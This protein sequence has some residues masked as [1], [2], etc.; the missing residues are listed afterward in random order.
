MGSDKGST[1][2]CSALEPES[3][4]AMARLRSVSVDGTKDDI[5]ARF[6]A[7]NKET[8]T[9]PWRKDAGAAEPE[10]GEASASGEEESTDD[11]GSE[12]VLPGNETSP[13]SDEVKDTVKSKEIEEIKVVDEAAVTDA[14]DDIKESEKPAE[15]EEIKRVGEVTA[16][17]DNKIADDDKKTTD[18]EEATEPAKIPEVAVSS[19][20]E[21]EAKIGTVKPASM[22]NL[23]QDWD[24]QWGGP[25]SVDT[26]RMT[27]TWDPSK[28][29]ASMAMKI[30]EKPKASPAV[31]FKKPVE[32]PKAPPAATVKKKNE[33][34]QAP[35]AAIAEPVSASSS[36][37]AG[38]DV[39]TDSASRSVTP[40]TDVEVTVSE[41]KKDAPTSEKSAPVQE[42]D[43]LASTT[44]TQAGE[45]SKK[46]RTRGKKGGKK[47]K[48]A[49]AQ[50]TKGSQSAASTDDAD[51]TEEDV[52]EAF[53]EFIDVSAPADANTGAIVELSSSVASTE[54]EDTVADKDDLDLSERVK[55]EGTEDLPAP[56]SSTS[57]PEAQ[58]T[59]E[60]IKFS[61]P[62]KKMAIH[63]IFLANCGKKE[64]VEASEPVDFF[65]APAS[66][67]PSSSAEDATSSMSGE[68]SEEK[69]KKFNRKSVKAQKLNTAN[70][71]VALPSEEGDGPVEATMPGDEGEHA[72]LESEA[73]AVVSAVKKTKKRG[74][75]GG[76]KVKKVVEEVSSDEASAWKPVHFAAFGVFGVAAGLVGYWMG[77]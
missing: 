59:E 45:P 32:K 11:I 48:K 16:I 74:K 67:A 27:A 31:N 69:A 19:E 63:P 52:T 22:A 6:E 24:A 9:V 3:A 66:P 39:T 38:S 15:A 1:N 18:V 17:D 49:A 75:K 29:F 51:T 28:F 42:K 54:P 47:A 13:Q 8:G 61:E 26:V 33:K 50:P 73:N 34:W 70:A 72:A 36:T 7:Q 44:G 55:S 77:A 76:R 71:F 30:S 62:V 57:T 10:V 25:K 35:P 65:P 53:P 68:P 2:Y 46:K 43:V 58:K 20:I 64:P 41:D 56:S 14:P 4:K 60:V 23:E 40:A 21:P 5:V 12:S 37:P